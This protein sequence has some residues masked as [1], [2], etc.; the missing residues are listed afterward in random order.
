MVIIGNVRL[1]QSSK[2]YQVTEETIE[3]AVLSLLKRR[4]Y[5]SFSVKDICTEAG[6]NRTTFYA[7]YQDINDFMIK[8]EGKLAQKIQAIWKPV[9]TLEVFNESVFIAFFEF[10]KEYKIFYKAFA[11]NHVPSFVAN[12]MLKKHKELFKQNL[13]RRNINYTDAEI[14]YHLHYFGGGLKAIC[15]RWLQNDCKETPEQMA[16]IIYDEYTNNARFS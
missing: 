10:V 6:I 8:F 16:K 13:L 14:D 9:G 11:K 15:G 2:R 1:E 7:H 12:D 4:D 5:D 3:K